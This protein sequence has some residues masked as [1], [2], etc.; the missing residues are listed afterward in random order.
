[1]LFLFFYVSRKPARIPFAPLLNKSGEA[2]PSPA[3]DDFQVRQGFILAQL[4]AQE[5]GRGRAEPSPRPLPG[6]AGLL[7]QPLAP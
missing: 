3:P 4:L 6:E 7:A 5:V 1:M 2:G